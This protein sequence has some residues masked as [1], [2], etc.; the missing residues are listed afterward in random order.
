MDKILEQTIAG[1][2]CTDLLRGEDEIVST[3]VRRFEHG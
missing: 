1:A 2:L 3:Y